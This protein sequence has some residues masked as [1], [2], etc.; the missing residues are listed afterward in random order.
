M[1]MIPCQSAKAGVRV[2]DYRLGEAGLR[3]DTVDLLLIRLYREHRVRPGA[4]CPAA[5]AVDL[6]ANPEI[7][8]RYRLSAIRRGFAEQIVTAG[9]IELQ[10]ENAR[11]RG[12]QSTALGKCRGGLLRGQYREGRRA[13]RI[14]P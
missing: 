9:R 13:G 11:F 2:P 7:R 4:Y 8:R 14:S 6:A 1:T 5:I 3:I 10:P 12:C